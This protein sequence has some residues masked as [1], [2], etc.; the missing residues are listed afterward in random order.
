[1]IHFG[2]GSESTGGKLINMHAQSE[3]QFEH[4][5]PVH[6]IQSCVTYSTDVTSNLLFKQI[7]QK[8]LK[9]LIPTFLKGKFT[10]KMIYNIQDKIMFYSLS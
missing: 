4:K 9:H 7:L 6:K 5:A 2:G 8:N 10:Y 3:M 1:M